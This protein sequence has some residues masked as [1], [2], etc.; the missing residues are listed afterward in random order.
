MELWSCCGAG[1]DPLPWPYPVHQLP[2]RQ[3]AP[4]MPVLPERYPAALDLFPWIWQCFPAAASISHVCCYG[5]HVWPLHC[6]P[7]HKGSAPWTLL[8]WELENPTEQQEAL[9]QHLLW[10]NTARNHPRDSS[11]LAPLALKPPSS[12]NEPSL[13]GNAAFVHPM[14]PKHL[15]MLSVFS[16]RSIPPVPEGR[17]SLSR[18]SLSQALCS[19]PAQS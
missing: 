19:F 8:P 12:A 16:G 1:S 7:L 18:K 14:S 10:K 3:E 4:W 15:H 17:A 6:T 11:A 2:A 13:T 9:N 5:E